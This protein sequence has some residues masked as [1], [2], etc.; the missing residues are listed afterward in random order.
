MSK[1]SGKLEE[2]SMIRNI[3]MGQQMEEYQSKFQELGDRLGA[4][5][6]AISQEIEAMKKRHEEEINELREEHA[7]A[8]QEL[9]A[10]LETKAAEMEETRKQD[11]QALGALLVTLGKNWM[12]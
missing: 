10:R 1:E 5:Q 8:I 3:L 4:A 6:D 9:T 2:L 7:T 12:E 11:K